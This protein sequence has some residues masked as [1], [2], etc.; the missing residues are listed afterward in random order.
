MTLSNISVKTCKGRCFERTFGSCRCDRDCVELGN[1]CLDFQ[2]TCIQPGKT[3]IWTCNKFRCG[4]KRWP[5]NRCSCSD[6]CVE[7]KDCCVNYYIVC[8]G[9]K[10]WVE[11]KCEDINEPQCPPGF[12]KPPV[13]LFSL[14]GFRAEYLHTWSGL[15]PVI[16]KLQKCGTYTPNMRPVYPTKTFPNHYTIV[17]GLYPESHGIIDNKIYDPHRNVSFTLKNAE[18]FNP[19]WY[20]GQPIWLTAMHQGLK[21]GTFFWPGSDVRINGTF[22]DL[23]RKYNGYVKHRVCVCVCVCACVRAPHFYTLY[24]EEPDSSGHN[25]GPVSSG[26]ILALQRVDNIVGM[27]MD[28]LKQ[29]NLHKCLNIIL[30]SD[31]GMETASCSK[32]A[33]L[34]TYMENVQD[35]TVIPGPAARLRPQNVPDEYF[36]Y[37]DQHFKAFMKELLPKRFHYVNNDRIERVH[38]YLDPQWQLARK[39]SEIKYC[40]GGFHGSDNRFMSMQAIFIGFGPGFKFKTQVD[41]FENIEIYNLICDLLGITPAYNNGTHGSLNHLLK[42]PVYIPR[43]PEEESHP[44][45]YPLMKTTSSLDIG[46]SCDLYIELVINSVSALVK[47]IEKYSLPYG[48]PRVL[49]KRSTYYLLYHHQYVSGYSQDLNMTLWSAYTVTKYDNRTASVENLSNCL[50][51]D[52]RIPSSS[53][54]TC[55]FYK[56]HHQLSYGFLFP[57]NTKKSSYEVLLNS[58]IVPMYH[59]FKV[60]WNYFYDVLLPKYTLARNGVNVVS[61]PVFDYDSNGLY[62]TPEK[63]KRLTHDPEVLVP[64]HYFIV[65]TSCKNI[66]QTPLQC[67]GA[68]DALSFIVPHRPDNSESCARHKRDSLWVEERMRFHTARVRDVELLTGLSFY[69]DRKQP[70]SDILQLKTYLPTF[71]ME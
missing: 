44:S 63:V 37:P 14:D 26:V 70:V 71:P 53:S 28:G 4:E 67:E 69:Q 60:L 3:H 49:Q 1:C 33:Y 34:S 41:P 50:H 11:E 32:T 64:T 15:L 45:V 40:N 51:V 21:A 61:G 6:D 25:F 38:F 39:P 31:H 20:Q 18:K 43:H 10:S 9:A 68:L 65:L 62:D 29:M 36:S 19:Q 66:S 46:C 42:N 55:S 54:K 12:A 47:K 2:E 13:L 48:R 16:S 27:L 58:N 56:N 23:Y 8:Q 59:E 22:P 30:L 35:I 5:E 7:N 24:L 17:T 57:P 52:I